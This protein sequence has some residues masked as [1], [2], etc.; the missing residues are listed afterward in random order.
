MASQLAILKRA[1]ECDRDREREK[2]RGWGLSEDVTL[3]DLMH[4][5]FTCMP[6]YSY[7]CVVHVTVVMSLDIC[8][9]SV[10]HNYLPSLVDCNHG[11]LLEENPSSVQ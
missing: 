9:M 5:L 8:V 6:G 7:P 10:K 1:L 4:F 11:Q 3:V 2:E